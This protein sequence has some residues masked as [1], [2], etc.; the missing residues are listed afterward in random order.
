MLKL[1]SNDT[2][3]KP[4]KS[5]SAVG[6]DTQYHALYWG[7]TEKTG[8]RTAAARALLRAMAEIKTKIQ[9]DQAELTRKL[10]LK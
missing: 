5:Y 3:K 2:S 4:I 9:Y 1:T 8:Q 10:S 7:Y 6:R